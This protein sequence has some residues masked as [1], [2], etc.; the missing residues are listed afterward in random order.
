MRANFRGHE[1]SRFALSGFYSVLCTLAYYPGRNLSACHIAGGRICAAVMFAVACLSRLVSNYRLCLC[2]FR[3]PNARPVESSCC[4][5][6]K[7]CHK[8][9]CWQ[10]LPGGLYVGPGSASSLAPGNA[11]SLSVDALQCWCV[12]TSYSSQGSHPLLGF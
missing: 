8:C 2:S 4:S 12:S 1:S 11:C 5:D 6:T 9:K 3:T 7:G 10:A